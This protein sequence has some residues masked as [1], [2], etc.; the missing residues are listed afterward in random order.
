[1]DFTIIRWII[2]VLIILSYTIYL[3]AGFV[4]FR[5]R[6]QSRSKHKHFFYN[7][8]NLIMILLAFGSLV[9]NILICLKILKPLMALNNYVSIIMGSVLFI[10]GAAGTFI[11]RYG[12]LKKNWSSLLKV[13]PE[14][15]M[16]DHGPYRIIRH[17]I[18]FFALFLFAGP[19]FIFPVLL[20][21]IFITLILV[22]YIILTKVEDDFLRTNLD[23][24]QKYAQKVRFRLIYGIW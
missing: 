6:I 24:Y 4:F 14:K 1:M 17:P 23:Y 22:G 20:N 9:V 10:I 18:Y 3:Q 8:I 21:F 2:F 15:N 16:I 7:I 19:L 13:F 5:E 12:Y 11:S